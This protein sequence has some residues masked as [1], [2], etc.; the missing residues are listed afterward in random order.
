MRK[1]SPRALV[2]P[3]I[4]LAAGAGIWFLD[5]RRPKAPQVAPPDRGRAERIAAQPGER[6]ARARDPATVDWMAQAVEAARL[7]QHA[8]G[9]D[10]DLFEARAGAAQAHALAGQLGP[11]QDQLDF[12]LKAAP[13]RRDLRELRGEVAWRIA[14][15]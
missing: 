15:E 12:L 4:A 5:A 10:P 14:F 13:E 11:A 3:A 2:F 6:L 9:S 7:F 8:I 1:I